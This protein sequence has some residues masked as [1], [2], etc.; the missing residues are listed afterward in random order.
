MHL[1][2]LH[3]SIKQRRY[4]LIILFKCLI[5]QYFIPLFQEEYVPNDLLRI[6]TGCS[7]K[8]FGHF[9]KGANFV[10]FLF[11]FLC[12]NSLLKRILLYKE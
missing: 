3:I 5:I 1:R 9:A 10:T 7:W 4:K 2:F 6:M 11:A 8:M 12:I